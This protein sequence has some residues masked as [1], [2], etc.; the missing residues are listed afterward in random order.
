MEMI[1]VLAV[2]AILASLLIPRV[3]SAINRARIN[4]AALE[5]NNFKTAI[6]EAYSNKGYFPGPAGTALTASIADATADAV[7]NPY[8]EKVLL[9]LNVVDKPF[10]VKVGAEGTGATEKHVLY[11]QSP[12]ASSAAVT[13]VLPNLSFDL[14]GSDGTNDIS[15]HAYVV[16]AKLNSVSGTDAL[17]LSQLMD[18]DALSTTNSTTADLLGRVIYPDPSGGPVDVLVYI[19]SR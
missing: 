17:E 2:I 12:A 16:C 19:S 10:N 11:L 6:V 1:G 4:S 14:D 15:G 5:I 3:F 13:G 8:D 9:S 18:G 7:N